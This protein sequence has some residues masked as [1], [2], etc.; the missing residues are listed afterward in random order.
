MNRTYENL[1]KLIEA[2]RYDMEDMYNKLDLFFAV[3]RIN[4]IEYIE[5]TGMIEPLISLVDEDPESVDELEQDLVI[6]SD[7]DDVEDVLQEEK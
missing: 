7:L 6:E 1:K 5:L 4:S 3:G 2:G